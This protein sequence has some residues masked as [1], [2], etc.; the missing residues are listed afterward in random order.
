MR[1]TAAL[2]ASLIVILITGV[3]A[4]AAQVEGPRG[5]VRT[6]TELNAA[7]RDIGLCPENIPVR[8][9]FITLSPDGGSEVTASFS[10]T[11]KGL[12]ADGFA[13]AEARDRVGYDEL[14]RASQPMLVG[15]GDNL[16]VLTYPVK[17]GTIKRKVFQRLDGEALAV[18]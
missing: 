16:W 2:A 14:L 4:C 9:P 5:P 3:S 15:T 6:L 8:S 7:L 18:G 13:T 10:C 11:G 12:A 1:T 17:N